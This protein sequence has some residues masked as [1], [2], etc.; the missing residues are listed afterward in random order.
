VLIGD[1]HTKGLSSDLKQNLGDVYEI[2][3]FVKPYAS[4]IELV[5]TVKEEVNRLTKDDVLVF[6]GGANDVSKNN[7]VKGFTQEINYL[8][9]NQ[10]ANCIVITVPHRFD[11]DY[12]SCVNTEIEV[13]NRKLTK[14]K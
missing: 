2:T 10:Q 11:L 3:G 6:W 4:V 1:S 9:R 8:R 7:A 12:N 13:Y 5:D 14:V